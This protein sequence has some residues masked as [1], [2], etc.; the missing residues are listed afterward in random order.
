MTD[1]MSLIDLVRRDPRPAPWAEGEK[2]PW[3]EPGFSAR[4]LREHLSQEHDWA[5]RRLATI[6]RQVDWIHRQI[7]GGRPGQIL[8]LGCGP[9]LYTSRLAALGHTCLGIDFSP[10]SIDYARSQNS[11]GCTYLLDDL[12][13]A[14]FGKGYDLVMFVYGELNVFRP[15]EA[16]GILARAFAGMKPGAALLLEV[17]TD[18]AVRRIGQAPAAWYSAESGLFSDRPHLCLQE[19]YWEE[20]AAVAIQRYFILDAVSGEGIRYASSMQAY[21]LPGYRSLLG[22]AGFR[23]IECYPSLTG[24]ADPAQT[25]LFVLL[26]RKS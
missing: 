19:N 7:L 25:D 17:H 9:G 20:E 13:R 8:D 5:S 24:G 15:G 2:I 23:G 18:A 4:M 6:D 11:P 1:E 21:T 14:E 26:A 10:A 3:N 12:R 22:A 16:E